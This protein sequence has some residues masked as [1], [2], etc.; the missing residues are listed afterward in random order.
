MRPH[1]VDILISKGIEFADIADC[2]TA[3]LRVACD[4]SINGIDTAQEKCKEKST[5]TSQHRPISDN[6]A[7]FD[8]AQRLHGY[9]AG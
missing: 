3:V 8:G 7:A 2:T 1:I 9:T 6:F 5:D 4:T